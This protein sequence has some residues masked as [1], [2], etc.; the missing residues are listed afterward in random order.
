MHDLAGA[1]LHARL[2][3][4]MHDLAAGM[5]DAVPRSGRFISAFK[6]AG[7]RVLITKA[8]PAAAAADAARAF[9]K[10]ASPPAM[11]ADAA[12]GVLSGSSAVKAAPAQ[13]EAAGSC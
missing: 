9:P 11:P 4:A 2:R 6:R 3:P 12:A 7:H 8:G 10:S 5:Q 1:T 13:L